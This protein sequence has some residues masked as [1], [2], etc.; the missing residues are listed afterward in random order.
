MFSAQ[1]QLFSAKCSENPLPG[2]HTDTVSNYLLN[3]LNHLAIKELCT[4][5]EL[6]ET[7]TELESEFILDLNFG[8][9]QNSK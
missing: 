1:R 7:S 5:Q 3:I 2:E 9:K 8:H 4:A 6:E